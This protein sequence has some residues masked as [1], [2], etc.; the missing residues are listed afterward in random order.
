MAVAL[1]GR[2]PRTCTLLAGCDG[3]L[4]LSQSQSLTCPR[5]FRARPVLQSSHAKKGA[6]PPARFPRPNTLHVH[7]QYPCTWP[8]S[9]KHRPTR[10]PRCF[11]VHHS[12][13]SLCHRLRY[14]PACSPQSPQPRQPASA[15]IPSTPGSIMFP[16]CSRP[17]S[18][19]FLVPSLFPPFFSPQLLHQVI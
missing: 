6:F 19:S 5:P 13:S 3:S 17:V 8:R 14:C 10:R 12:S 2:G 9:G 16:P 18:W 7:P 1:C 15:C 11:P 4:S